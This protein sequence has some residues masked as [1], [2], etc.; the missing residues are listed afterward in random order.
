MPSEP[1][2]LSAFGRR[3]E[4]LAA[5]KGKSKRELAE[6]A[7]VTPSKLT[8]TLRDEAHA[9]ETGKRWYRPDAETIEALAKALDLKG[10]DLREFL[11]LGTLAR[12]PPE[13]SELID[14]LRRQLLKEQ[15]DLLRI[16]EHLSRLGIELP[17][18]L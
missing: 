14:R 2:E 18:E 13:A 4:E 10:R 11:D 1:N 6:A 15:K 12:C 16:R 7:G 9:K 17:K 8:D 5:A 3:L